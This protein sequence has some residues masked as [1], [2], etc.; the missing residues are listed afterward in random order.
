M[1]VIRSA[2]QHFRRKIFSI[3]IVILFL[4]EWL[5]LSIVSFAMNDLL[6][7]ELAFV[8]KVAVAMVAPL[9]VALIVWWCTKEPARKS[10]QR[11]K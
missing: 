2:M 3:L 4:W 10:A 9:L 7:L 8:V 11:D 5:I 1:V 6:S